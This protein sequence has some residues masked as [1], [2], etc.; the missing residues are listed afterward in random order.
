MPGDF[1]HAVS[2][3]MQVKI[4]KVGRLGSKRPVCPADI[5]DS[6]AKH[7]HRLGPQKEF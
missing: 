6:A 5:Y 7:K 4:Y 2:K 1:R 3:V